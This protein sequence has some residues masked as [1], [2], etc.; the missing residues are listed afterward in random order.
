MTEVVAHQGDAG[1]FVR[2]V[3]AVSE[4]HAEVGLGEGRGIV[5][6]V[7]DH[8]D[9]SLLLIVEDDLGF[10][11]GKGFG[12]DLVDP[13]LASDVTGGTGV[14]AGDHDGNESK[15]LDFRDGLG[16]MGV[17]LVGERE[18]AKNLVFLEKDDGGLALVLP[19]FDHGR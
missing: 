14:V 13:R 9:F 16:G 7:A 10:V 8:G 1:G 4:G 17:E 2:D 3:G 11:L 19:G 12:V 18:G 6:A 5:E 15:G